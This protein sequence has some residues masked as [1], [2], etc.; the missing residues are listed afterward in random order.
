MASMCKCHIGMGINRHAPR[1]RRASAPPV[2]HRL[3]TIAPAVA[4]QEMCVIVVSFNIASTFHQTALIT[5]CFLVSAVAFSTH[6]AYQDT[7]WSQDENNNVVGAQPRDVTVKNRLLGRGSYVLVF[8]SRGELFVT[9]RSDSK[10]WLSAL[11]CKALHGLLQ[12]A[13]SLTS[14]CIRLIALLHPLSAI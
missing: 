14:T 5:A 4:K 2:G 11:C 12:Q 8:N 10:V 13:Q 9:K 3:P 7:G 6:V 1:F